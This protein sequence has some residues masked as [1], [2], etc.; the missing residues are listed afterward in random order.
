MSRYDNVLVP[1][2]DRYPLST[3]T[4]IDICNVSP[5]SDIKRIKE[6]VRDITGV[7][8]DAFVEVES[9]RAGKQYRISYPS[10]EAAN[11]A[12]ALLNSHPALD[13]E[14]IDFG[15]PGDAFYP[16]LTDLFTIRTVEAVTCLGNGAPREVGCYKYSKDDNNGPWTEDLAWPDG[17]PTPS[18]VYDAASQYG[19]IHHVTVMLRED[20][21][22]W[23]EDPDRSGPWEATVQFFD[24]EDAGRMDQRVDEQ[25][26]FVGWLVD[27]YVLDTDVHAQKALYHANEVRRAQGLPPL[28]PETIKMR[29]EQARA[30]ERQA[31]AASAAA[32]GTMRAL[33]GSTETQTQNKDV[34][35]DSPKSQRSHAGS[36][37]KASSGSSTFNPQTPPQ[38]DSTGLADSHVVRGD[39]DEQV[40]SQRLGKE[41]AEEHGCSGGLQDLTE[42]YRKSGA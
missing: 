12:L 1:V 14:G 22:D 10:S 42:D 7:A 33:D 21:D 23:Y 36:D 25:T 16:T 39:H 28:G 37:S 32:D 24:P 6:L 31:A 18:Q 2:R 34:S 13:G 30:K 20:L 27:V 3:E 15:R 8:T 17:V 38:A 9:L 19:A 26:P 29:V 4:Q 40:R 35:S 5:F 11:R 41:Q